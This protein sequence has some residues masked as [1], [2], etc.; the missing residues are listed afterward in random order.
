MNNI[1]YRVNGDKI[2]SLLLTESS[3]L[4]SSALLHTE[5]EFT[6]A[7]QKKITLVTNVEIKFGAIKSITK[8]NADADIRIKYKGFVG[9][10]SEAEF[11]FEEEVDCES[12]FTYLE[13]EQYFNKNIIS[14]NAIKANFRYFLG[15]LLT[16]F[17]TCVA[18]IEAVDI[19]NGNR[20]EIRDAKNKIFNYIVSFLGVTGVLLIGCIIASFIL[21]KIFGRIKNPPIQTKFTKPS[22]KMLFI[23]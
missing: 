14:L 7:L 15:L 4:L 21:Y 11:A 23:L 22:S 3:I 10:P 13:K 2:Q 20:I 1:V 5:E 19:K 9:L 16:I 6:A 18:Y 12:F 8:E 17:A